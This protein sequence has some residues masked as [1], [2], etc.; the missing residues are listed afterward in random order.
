MSRDNLTREEARG[1]AELIGDIRYDVTLDLTGEELFPSATI[2]D[3]RCSQP[4]A[5][6]FIDFT[7][8]EVAS[9]ELNGR[10]VG[11][12]AFVG[13][14]IRLTELEEENRLRILATAE[15]STTGK[16]I[17]RTVDPVDGRAYLYTDLEPF[18]AHRFFPCFD[19]PDLKGTFSFAALAPAEW[20]V[21][22]NMAAREPEDRDGKR[23]WTF[24]ATPP[25]PTYI[26]VVVAGPYHGV[27]DRHGD[28]DLGVWCR[29]SLAEHLDAD[30]ILEITKQGFS[31]FEKA[32]RSPYPFHKYDQVFVPDFRAGA[33]ENAGCVTFN[34]QRYVFRS[35]V[36][37]AER[38]WRAGT[39]THEMAHMWFGNLVTMRWW[40]DLW[41]NESFATYAGTLAQAEAT[42][43]REAWA[44]FAGYEKTWAY[45]QDQLPTTHP[46]SA[47]VP[48]T[49]SIHL[50]FDG[51]TYAK[52]AS[53]LKQLVAWVGKERFLDGMALYFRRHQWGN[54]SLRD[55]LVVLEEVSG[56][57]LG[58]WS[59]EWLETAGVVTLRPRVVTSGDRYTEVAIEQRAPEDHPTLR[60]HRIAVGLY[61]AGDEGLVRRRRVELD[62]VGDLTIV[63]DL[64]GE[65]VADLLLVNDD[66]LTYAKIRFDDRSLRTLGERLGDIREPLSRTLCWAACWDM[67]RDAE[68]PARDY[69][70]LV[71]RHA[72]R[73]TNPEVL[74]HLLQQA[75]SAVTRYG[76]PGNRDAGLAKLADGALRALE[77]AAPASDEQLTWTRA[78][79]SAASTGHQLATVRGLL[80]GSTSF[81][82]L[83]VDTELRW[84][85]VQSLAAAGADDAEE[86]IAEEQRRDPT[87]LGARHAET[88]R[89]SAEPREAK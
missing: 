78:F 13:R 7:G 86:L 79:I 72:E 36:T 10:T 42:R 28:I 67:T 45:T 53:V 68:M 41:L 81:D 15:N 57:D 85:I 83:A 18:D 89:A 16:G 6:T 66:D 17:V 22:S 39:I 35:K 27:R 40:H 43:F 5:E 74:R 64:A 9:I 88:A 11:I 2:V 8:A 46:I 25:I 24:E 82:G 37:G 3:F 51:I 47:D 55:F 70:D 32:F 69:V 84:H 62:V 58:Q 44:S 1:R 73:E 76:D 60:S 59:K 26:A 20:H 87:D 21:L 75:T 31:F 65:P 4:G 12:D 29:E 61:D 34:E 33:M 80:D 77:Q 71:L 52:G 63:A 56:R 19:Q 30:E 50:N 48:D 38:E 49:D 14:R 23:L 54:A